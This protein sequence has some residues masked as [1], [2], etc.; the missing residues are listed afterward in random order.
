MLFFNKR[1]MKNKIVLKEIK[2]FYLFS[3]SNAPTPVFMGSN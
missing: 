2:G 3:A 1:P